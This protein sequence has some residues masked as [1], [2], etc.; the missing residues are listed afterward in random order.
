MLQ[1][2]FFEASITGVSLQ[3][4]DSKK[5]AVSLMTAPA[6]VEIGHL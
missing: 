2:L 5:P 3:P 4:T 6:E 1:V